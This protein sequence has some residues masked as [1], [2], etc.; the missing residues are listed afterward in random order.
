MLVLCA[1][2]SFFATL[3]A[4]CRGT[5]SFVYA[6]RASSGGSEPTR[7]VGIFFRERRGGSSQ[8]AAKKDGYLVRL[9]FLVFCALQFHPRR[10]LA[11]GFAVPSMALGGEGYFVGS[12]V[13]TLN[14]ESF[15]QVEPAEE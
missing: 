10:M 5:E 3:A 11:D 15:D 1:P 14:C 7:A 2:C 4:H 6:C 13:Q 12:C 8:S 9:H